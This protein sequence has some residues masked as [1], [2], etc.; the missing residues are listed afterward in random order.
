MTVDVHAQSTSTLIIGTEWAMETYEWFYHACLLQSCRNERSDLSMCSQC[1]CLDIA[2]AWCNYLE[3]WLTC[4]KAACA[5]GQSK[6]LSPTRNVVSVS[7]LWNACVLTKAS[8]ERQRLVT[9]SPVM[10]SPCP[11]RQCITFIRMS[12]AHNAVLLYGMSCTRWAKQ[13]DGTSWSKLTASSSK[14]VLVSWLSN[15]YSYF[16]GIICA[17]LTCEWTDQPCLGTVL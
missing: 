14:L 9:G 15:S 11:L 7:F 13:A 8:H 16:D 6:T 4:L 2:Y 17:K 10:H 12:H 3:A 1:S 5:F